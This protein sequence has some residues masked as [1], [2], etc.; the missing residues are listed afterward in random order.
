MSDKDRQTTLASSND[1]SPVVRAIASRVSR[2]LASPA[3]RNA[4]RRVREVT[5]RASGSPHRVEY[6]HQA[7]DP[8]SHLAAQTLV[9]LGEAYDIELVISVAGPNAG[10]TNP[11]PELLR[12]Y[13]R[14][15]AAAIAPHR[16]LVFGD[17]GRAPERGSVRLAEQLLVAA[18]RDGSLAERI[19]Q[20]GEALW[21]GEPGRLERY[22]EDHA[23]ATVS[24]TESTIATATERRSKLGHYSG[25]M[26]HYGGEWY[27]GIDRIDHLERRLSDLGLVREGAK[28]P[29]SPRPKI[30]AGPLRDTGRLT[31]EYFPSLRSPYTAFIHDRSVKIARETGVNFVIRPVLPMVMRGVPVTFAK[32]A[33]IMS[34]AA[35]EAEQLGV[36]FGKMF[37]PIGKP[38]E[39]GFSLYPWAEAQGRGAEFIS[40][41]LGAAFAEGRNTGSDAGLRFVV[42][43]AG[44][45][46][47]EAQPVLD[48]EDWR[49]GLERNRLTMVDDL[50]LWGVP[51]YRLRGPGD[52]P[53]FSAWGQDRLWL[54]AREIQRRL[55]G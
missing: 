52:E 37:D 25:A 35:R 12:D 13:A 2:L 6:F 20:I 23:A 24:D 22:A 41:F 34:D 1:P 15:D 27:W 7:D 48:T 44:L 39:R 11:E 21:S 42:E 30:E 38:V 26:F 40:S 33:Y 8:Y 55:S 46:W 31:L 9:A 4:M 54:I 17:T 47:S 14:R 10:P 3:R 43:R 49:E 28:V 29:V 45:R 32:A 36:P 19:V 53:E 51:S 5:R 16:G 18:N 50:G